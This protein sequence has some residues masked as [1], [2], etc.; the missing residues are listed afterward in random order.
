[1]LYIVDCNGLIHRM[2]HGLPPLAR[3][4]DG[5][6]V[7]VAQGCA[8]SFWRLVKQHPSH[9]AV[10]LDGKGGSTARKAM[11]PDYKANR[12]PMAPELACQMQFGRRAAEAFGFRV[13]QMDGVE[14]DDLIAT[15]ARLA[16]QAGIDVCIMSSDKDLMQLVAPGVMMFDLLKNKPIME[17]DVEKKFGVPPHKV[18]D[19][20][21]MKG[22]ATDGIK[23]IHGIGDVWAAKLLNQYGDLERVLEMAHE[24]KGKMGENVR[25]DAEQAR[26]ARRLVRLDMHIE[27]EHTHSDFAYG[28]FDTRAVL[29]FLDECELVTLRNEIAAGMMQAA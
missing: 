15:H 10:I 26:L 23:G 22:D 24:I 14:A 28:E 13:V 27:V 1:M 16:R 12:K 18:L 5:H 25:R 9:V 2:F 29:D 7:N 21:A 4:S 11:S 8:S 20:L 17:A 6:P 3:G 19:F